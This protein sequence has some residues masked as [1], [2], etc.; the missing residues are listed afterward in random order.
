MTC[1]PSG[2]QTHDSFMGVFIHSFKR[3]PAT[4]TRNN[5][6]D[7]NPRGLTV[8]PP[9][10]HTFHSR[11][12]WLQRLCLQVRFSRCQ[13]RATEGGVPPSRF[14]RFSSLHN[15][16]SFWKVGTHTLTLTH[17]HTQT[18]TYTHTHTHTHTR[19]RI[20]THTHTQRS[21][22]SCPAA[23]PREKEKPDCWLDVHC[24]C[25]KRAKRRKETHRKRTGG[26]LRSV[27]FFFFFFFFF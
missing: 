1:S 24:T 7:T 18:H 11:R 26:A 2:W 27:F 17:T 8:T 6:S 22:S 16:L 10:R 5:T 23:A 25:S 3:Q 20:H 19:T 4:H 12:S 15:K 9:E 21:S 14:S 13:L